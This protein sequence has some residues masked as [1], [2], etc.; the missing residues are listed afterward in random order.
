[1]ELSDLMVD[2]VTNKEPDEIVNMIAQAKSWKRA[3]LHGQAE[4]F[5]EN[6]TGDI[7]HMVDEYHPESNLAYA[8]ELIKEMDQ[9]GY[10]IA[11]NTRNIIEGTK[12]L[13]VAAIPYNTAMPGIPLIE[14]Q[15][16]IPGLSLNSLICR[17]IC[18]LYLAY[19]LLRGAAVYENEQRLAE[20]K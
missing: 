14:V 11:I 15:E 17:S 7:I 16:D 3:E 6:G 4:C 8:E 19:V 20:S 12:K 13:L 1:M 10:G 5:V 2:V 18:A 9:S